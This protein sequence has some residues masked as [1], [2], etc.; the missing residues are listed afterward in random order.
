MIENRLIDSFKQDV[1]SGK[2]YEQII[3]RKQNKLPDLKS[4]LQSI[5]TNKRG[6]K[7]GKEGVFDIKQ[8]F[9][10]QKK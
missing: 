2:K 7:T 1:L 6:K 4:N 5:W 3:L 8:L 10:F 9:E